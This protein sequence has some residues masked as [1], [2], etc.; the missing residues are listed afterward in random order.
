MG[1]WGLSLLLALEDDRVPRAQLTKLLKSLY[2][3]FRQQDLTLLPF[4]IGVVGIA[5]SD[6]ESLMSL[7]MSAIKEVVDHTTRAPS[8]EFATSLGAS[9]ERE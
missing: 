5:E 8:R 2:L 4:V 1:R 7:S 3:L 6:E 9:G